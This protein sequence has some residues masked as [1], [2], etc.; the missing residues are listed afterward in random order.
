M[1]HDTTPA[2]SRRA[3]LGSCARAAVL[4]GIAATAGTL[5]RRGQFRSCPDE[6]LAC[7][8]CSHLSRC[9]LP[10]AAAVRRGRAEQENRS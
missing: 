2:V 5:A 8:C 1:N 3:W 4:G 7:A 6:S 10:R 9:G